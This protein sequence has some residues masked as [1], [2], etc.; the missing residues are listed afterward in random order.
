VRDI[1][2][3]MMLVSWRSSPASDG[4]EAGHTMV[5]L[6]QPSSVSPMLWYV[7]RLA[8]TGMH[9][10]SAAGDVTLWLFL[11][12]ERRL[13]TPPTPV[14][15]Q[16][17]A[18]AMDSFL[19]SLTFVEKASFIVPLAS[20]KGWGVAR[21]QNDGTARQYINK[22]SKSCRGI[23]SSDILH[24]LPMVSSP[25]PLTLSQ[26]VYWLSDL[27]LAKGGVA[28]S[29]NDDKII[30]KGRRRFASSGHRA[31][32][33]L[34]RFLRWFWCLSSAIVFLRVRLASGT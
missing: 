15:V 9:M 23:A 3:M 22:S 24:V 2:M 8:W 27:P 29:E 17:F 26:L 31:A 4:T 12:E 18:P 10:S 14:N 33:Q 1:A 19:E 5:P 34:Y 16:T 7:F 25:E 13:G 20:G 28:C 30:N 21:C 6:R 32:R 11:D